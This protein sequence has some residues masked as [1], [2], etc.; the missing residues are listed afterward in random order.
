MTRPFDITTVSN[1][2]TLDAKGRGKLI[3]TVTNKS[4]QALRAKLAVV[5][6]DTAKA[7]W[8]TVAGDAVRSWAATDGVQQVEVN[9][10]V[11]PG[12]PPGKLRMRLDAI[13]EI[14]PEEDLTEGP[15]IS[16]IIPA[17]EAAPKKGGV[18]WWVWLIIALVVLTIVGVGTWLAL[19]KSDSPANPPVATG[20]G[21]S[22]PPVTPPSSPP[23]PPPP[24]AT[25]DFANPQI[26]SAEGLMALDICR[27]WGTDCG[28][29]AA[30]AF[31]IQHGWAMATRF[32]IQQDTPPTVVISTKQVCK[33][34]FCDRIDFV[35]CGKVPNLSIVFRTR[36]FRGKQVTLPE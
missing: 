26:Q 21:A 32:T 6:F 4:Q 36:E 19:R 25:Q 7:G 5:H 1:A 15:E 16:V 18:P 14:R 17:V 9:V 20:G 2:L 33:E 30:D 10:A 12:T 35:Q 3:F 28:K 11:P 22:A 31:C 27:A 23:P 13:S 8:I 24:P 29:P 34:G